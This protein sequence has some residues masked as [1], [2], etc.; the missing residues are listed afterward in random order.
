MITKA[1]F[2]HTAILQLNQVNTGKIYLEIG[3]SLHHGSHTM[4][5][6]LHRM[7]MSVWMDDN[8]NLYNYKAD[9]EWCML[10]DWEKPFHK[11]S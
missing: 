2:Y 1:S 9:A 3:L 5:A 10:A 7:K 6:C 11:V 4:N 8:Q